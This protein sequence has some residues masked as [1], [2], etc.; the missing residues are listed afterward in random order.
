MGR[1]RITQGWEIKGS[2][3]PVARC[4]WRSGGASHKKSATGNHDYNASSFT[5]VS[6]SGKIAA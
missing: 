2:W 3:L 5:A 4:S 6:S 1:V